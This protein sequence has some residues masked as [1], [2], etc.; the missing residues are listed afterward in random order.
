MDNGYIKIINSYNGKTG[1]SVD[2]VFK[3]HVQTGATRSKLDGLYPI[4]HPTSRSG[5]PLTSHSPQYSEAIKIALN[6]RPVEDKANKACIALF[7]KELDIPKSNLTIEAGGKSRFKTLQAKG[8]SS[9]ML[10]KLLKKLS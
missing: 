7:A 6:A 8:V 4:T 2:I 9:I 10:A 5:T 1:K 3:V